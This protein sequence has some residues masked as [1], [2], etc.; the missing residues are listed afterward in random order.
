[1]LFII[2]ISFNDSE[3]EV[4]QSCPTLCDPMDCSFP[5]SS[6]HGIFQARVLECVAISFFRGSSRLRIEPGS[7][8]LREDALPSKPPGK[9]FNDN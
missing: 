1:M 2:V 7:P 5:G 8:A 4:T 6:F 9:P 3:S